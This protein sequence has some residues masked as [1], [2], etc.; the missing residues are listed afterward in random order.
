MNFSRSQTTDILNRLVSVGGTLLLLTLSVGDSRAQLQS[1]SVA[2]A[3]ST[4]AAQFTLQVDVLIQPTP[5]DQL[6]TQDWARLFQQIE[7][8]AVFRSGRNGELSRV[9]N[10]DVRGRKS[11]QAVGLLNRDGSVSFGN[12]RFV[13][14]DPEPL[15][16]W[17]NKLEQFGADGP[18][19]EHPR[20]GLDEDQ[21]R[22]VLKLL[23]TP[24]EQPVELRSADEAVR[25]L[26]LPAELP[27]RFTDAARRRAEDQLPETLSAGDS[28]TGLSKGTALAIALG[29]FGLGFRPK[30]SE[31]SIVL[32]V[33]VG[34][35]GDNLYPVGWKNTA[36]ITT[37]V[38]NLART[39]PVDLQDADLEALIR[40]IAQKLSVRHFYAQRTLL[41]DGRDIIALK[42]SRAPDR[43]SMY[44]LM[45][46]VSSLHGLGFGLRTDEAGTVFLWVT[47]QSEE[48]HWQQRFSHVR[49]AP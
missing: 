30:M 2:A 35:E 27:V 40:L 24:V 21:F 5:A 22:Q 13:L 47:T 4:Q 43:I 48:K 34:G 32:E 45:S 14:T 10:A 15:Q 9:E 33:D 8:R 41:T 36:P 25:T 31:G 42:Y 1:P 26:D 18:P 12:E 44:R 37:A 17:L 7:R 39:F 38:P 6:R 46:S 23:S 20:W 29:R 3:S 16:L 28:L 11:V 19:D 49:V